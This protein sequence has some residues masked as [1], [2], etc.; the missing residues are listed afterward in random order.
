V[1]ASV[2]HEE[3][4]R[5]SPVQTI[6]ASSQISKMSERERREMEL[7]LQKY[8]EIVE[9][10]EGAVRDSLVTIDKV[11]DKMGELR[12]E[13]L[14]LEQEE[15]RQKKVSTTGTKPGDG[16]IMQAYQPLFADRRSTDNNMDLLEKERLQNQRLS[17]TLGAAETG[18]IEDRKLTRLQEKERERGRSPVQKEHQQQ[19]TP[20]IVNVSPGR[21]PY[22]HVQPPAM[23]TQKEQ[24][25]RRDR[26]R[27]R[28]DEENRQRER[29]RKERKERKE[30]EVQDKRRREREKI[31]RKQR[32]Q[33]TNPLARKSVP[34]L[35]ALPGVRY[36]TPSMAEQ[37]IQEDK[38]KNHGK[39]MNTVRN[40]WGLMKSP[41]TRDRSPTPS[42]RTQQER[43]REARKKAFKEVAKEKTM[44]PA[45][46]MPPT[47]VEAVQTPAG[48]PKIPGAFP[49]EA[50]PTALPV[51][52]PK[53]VLNK[54]I[55]FNVPP[56]G[57]AESV[58]ETPTAKKIQ[59]RSIEDLRK[60]VNRT[61]DGDNKLNDAHYVA[62]R[63]ASEVG[64]YEP[65][66]RK[67]CSE[68]PKIRPL[69][70]KYGQAKSE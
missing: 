19:A 17:D 66:E 2:F 23:E 53:T 37:A 12:H 57:K 56:G 51:K 46:L 31:E 8:S 13:I 24:A 10:L 48:S 6:I 60:H 22:I 35:R 45:D 52:K 38:Q 16:K 50:A 42:I 70:A 11:K 25:A 41:G 64:K 67:D 5:S 27:Q 34:D 7:Q 63:L 55:R 32:E 1:R 69:E 9:K 3:G 33:L 40:V 21:K 20:R 15:H 28:L 29:E 58:A 14:R 36:V 65:E 54:E 49:A 44:V 47:K 39:V 30:R 4:E 62:M 59:K 26:E 18:R 43:D 68:I 61:E